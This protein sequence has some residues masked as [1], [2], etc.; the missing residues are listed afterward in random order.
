MAASSA[1]PS[2]RASLPLQVPAA[3]TCQL[4]ALVSSPQ[5][6]HHPIQHRHSSS[7]FTQEVTPW[8]RW[9]QHDGWQP[10][11]Y[12]G[13]G[14]LAL[15]SRQDQ[16]ALQP[17]LPPPVT[18]PRTQPSCSG[19]AGGGWASPPFLRL[20]PSGNNGARGAKAV[21]R[22]KGRGRSGPSL[23]P[24]WWGRF[25]EGARV[26]PTPARSACSTRAFGAHPS[27]ASGR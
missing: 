9:V 2:P 8:Q 15:G 24:W 20:E 5:P 19:G 3:E 6:A 18:I 16:D 22:G 14:G 1:L 7:G 13:V 23:A 25:G 21:G 4:V 11:G 26:R 27:S 10:E 17:P 12:G